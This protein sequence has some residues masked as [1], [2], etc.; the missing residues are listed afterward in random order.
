MD[1][2]MVGWLEIS[3]LRYTDYATTGESFAEHCGYVEFLYVSDDTGQRFLLELR[4]RTQSYDTP[5]SK[6]LADHRDGWSDHVCF[7]GASSL[8]CFTRPPHFSCQAH[9]RDYVVHDIYLPRAH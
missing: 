5:V 7:Y 8:H 6:G 9:A 2:A 3:L 1:K 4:K